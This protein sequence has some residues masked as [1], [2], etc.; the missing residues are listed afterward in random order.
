MDAQSGHWNMFSA[1]W[2]PSDRASQRRATYTDASQLCHTFTGSSTRVLSNVWGS[3]SDYRQCR[4]NLT[5]YAQLFNSSECLVLSSDGAISCH[6]DETKL[7]IAPIGTV[8]YTT[9]GSKEAS[10]TNQPSGFKPQPH[11][12]LHCT[13]ESE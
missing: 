9:Q 10:P 6:M 3:D 7:Y 5:R 12:A 1:I 8:S 11:P 4:N 2:R 13:A